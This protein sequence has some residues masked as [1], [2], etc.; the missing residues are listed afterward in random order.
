MGGLPRLSV[1]LSPIQNS[2]LIPLHISL[3][4]CEGRPDLIF[5]PASPMFM[6][7]WSACHRWSPPSNMRQTLIA[8]R[9]GGNSLPFILS[10]SC[11][12]NFRIH[13]CLR[14]PKCFLSQQSLG[15]FLTQHITS[16]FMPWLGFLV[17][18]SIISLIVFSLDN[19]RCRVL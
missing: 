14:H 4:G 13:Q 12:T 8:A 17:C 1:G 16:P 15:N 6:T 7:E 11:N 9:D 2:Y 19:Y 3:A 5:K 18:N 10:L